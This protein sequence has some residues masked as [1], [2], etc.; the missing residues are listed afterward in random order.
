MVFELA[1]SAPAYATA[2]VTEH[3]PAEGKQYQVQLQKGR[4]SSRILPAGGYT[5]VASAKG[6][7][8][9]RAFVEVTADEVTAL[10][11]DL[12]EPAP[13]P[14]SLTEQ[15]TRCGLDPASLTLRNLVVDGQTVTLD[16]SSQTF[17]SDVQVVNITD[18][19]QAKTILGHPDEL[20]PGG[21]P[22]YGKMVEP[23]PSSLSSTRDES[24]LLLDA[25]FA[26]REYVYGNSQT[27]IGW[28]NYLNHWLNVNIIPFPI[29]IF[30][31]VTVGPWGL[32]NIGAS[33]LFC[34]TLRVHYTGRVQITGTG[35]TTIEVATYEQYG[36]IFPVQAFTS[37]TF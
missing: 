15:L 21:Q 17:A 37:V 32:L 29:W 1:D 7:K 24:N 25:R 4:G 26:I 16:A 36:L 11:I 18:I 14:P 20:W 28:K 27:V 12:D 33:G 10:C 13:H 34:D 35:P 3:R 19:D 6:F 8:P 5:V 22:R 9:H 23:Q 30:E 31:T 2:L